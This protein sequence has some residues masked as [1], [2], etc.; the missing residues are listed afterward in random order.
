MNRLPT[1]RLLLQERQE[2]ITVDE[3][4][5][6][7]YNIV[8]SYCMRPASIEILHRSYSA[9]KICNVQSSTIWNKDVY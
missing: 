5:P 6:K 2:G 4:I 7:Y 9:E 3:L 1:E 8:V